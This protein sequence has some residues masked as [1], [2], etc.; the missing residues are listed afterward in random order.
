M[1]FIEIMWKVISREPGLRV[2]MAALAPLASALAARDHQ[3]DPMFLEPQFPH[4]SA[5]LA[6]PAQTTSVVLSR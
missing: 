4:V 5:G 6:L 2:R 1:E 3:I